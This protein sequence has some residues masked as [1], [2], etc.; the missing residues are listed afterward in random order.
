M[1]LPREAGRRRGSGPG[2]SAAARRVQP[3]SSA[4]ASGRERDHGLLRQQE[5]NAAHCGLDQCH[6]KDIIA[7]KLAWSAWGK[8]T[9]T[10]I[11]TAVVDLC[12]YEDCHSGDYSPP[13]DRQG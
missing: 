12:A 4:S 7:R 5:A 6:T 10:A 2:P 1:T 8:P 9:A 11:G 13:Y 3:A